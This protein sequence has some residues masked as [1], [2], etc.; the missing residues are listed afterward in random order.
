MLVAAGSEQR[1]LEACKSIGVR[2]EWS[3]QADGD[4]GVS[5]L[6]LRSRVSVPEVLEELE[7]HAPDLIGL[8][9]PNHWFIGA[10]YDH[11][12]PGDEPA[13]PEAKA[14]VTVAKYGGEGVRV[15]VVDS[16]FLEIGFRRPWLA[17][18]VEADP[19]DIEDPD[20]DRNGFVDFAAGHGTF[21][22]G[23]VRQV[24]PD[25]TIVVE[26]ALDDHGLVSE[27]DLSVQVLQA[28]RRKPHILN[29]SFG[30]Y[31]RDDRSPLGLALW[32]KQLSDR[33]IVVVAAAG[34]DA[35]DDRFYPAALPWVTGVGA[36]NR[37][38]TGR[39]AFSN[40]GEWVDCCAP[41]EDLLNAYAQGRYRTEH[42]ELRSFRGL[43]RWSGTSFAAPLVAGAIAARMTSEGM[44]A[45]KARDL[46]L[47][48]AGPVL[49]GIGPY[50]AV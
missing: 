49:E 45:V 17:R 28:L 50:V 1:A 24:A 38:G 26:Q 33:E 30:G 9:T 32:E 42:G 2:A 41:G 7:H 31:T 15:A 5:R 3:G 34:N 43:A 22:A 4:G 23:C 29:L 20:S 27:D 44:S 21:V 8:V 39:A 10:P 46:V 37:E 40:F 12:G 25:S 19:E 36:A 18:G 35:T 16:G 14:R 48:D 11:F 13:E 6:Q 47:A